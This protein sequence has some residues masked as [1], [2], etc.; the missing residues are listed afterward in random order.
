MSRKADSSTSS[1]ETAPIFFVKQLDLK[2]P[3]LPQRW[4]MASLAGHLSQ[5]CASYPHRVH[6]PLCPCPCAGTPFGPEGFLC[7]YLPRR[8]PLDWIASS[9]ESGR[10]PLSVCC[11]SPTASELSS[12]LYRVRSAVVVRA[13]HLVFLPLNGQEL[14]LP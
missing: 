4:Q 6:F 1:V 14:S 11:C 9:D 12:S 7:E 2:C 5:G 10:V 8:F 3:L 13:L